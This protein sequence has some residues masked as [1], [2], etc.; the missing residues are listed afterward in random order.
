MF[1][2]DLWAF[3]GIAGLGITAYCSGKN[4]GIKQTVIEY[5]MRHVV[6]KQQLQIADLQ[7]KLSVLEKYNRLTNNV[8]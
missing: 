3:L 1:N 5:E 6:E 8:T 4:N 7:Q 2:D